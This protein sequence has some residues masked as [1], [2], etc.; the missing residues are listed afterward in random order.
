PC[1]KPTNVLVWA[2]RD[3]GTSRARK[4]DSRDPTAGR[5]L[6]KRGLDTRVSATPRGGTME[7]G[8]PGRKGRRLRRTL[9]MRPDLPGPRAAPVLPGGPGDRQG[10][11]QCGRQLSQL[12]PTQFFFRLPAGSRGPLHGPLSLG[13]LHAHPVWPHLVD[14]GA[15]PDRGTLPGP[16]PGMA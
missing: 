9:A 10:D 7:V 11:G 4:M 14:P 5:C 3:V 15:V 16:F 1:R 8:R 2:T 6:A 12:R 13:V